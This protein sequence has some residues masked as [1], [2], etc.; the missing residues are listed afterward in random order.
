MIQTAQS[1][2]METMATKFTMANTTGP[3]TNPSQ[4]ALDPQFAV[5]FLDRQR[6]AAIAYTRALS[7]TFTMESGISFTRTT[8]SFPTLDRT[9][10]ALSF[11]DG[12]YEIGRAHV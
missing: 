12:S 6:N 11:G 10:P 4:T 1:M 5:G 7:P 3:T 8:P 9:D 2:P